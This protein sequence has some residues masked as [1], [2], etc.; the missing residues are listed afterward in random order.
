MRK[1]GG[2]IFGEG[3][4]GKVVDAKDLEKHLGQIKSIVFYSNKNV[5][6]NTQSNSNSSYYIKQQISVSASVWNNRNSSFVEK[7]NVSQIV[8]KIFFNQSA[9]QNVQNTSSK[10]VLETFLK[11]GTFPKGNAVFEEIENMR[12]VSSLDIETPLFKHEGNTILFAVVNGNTICPVYEKYDMDLS[13]FMKIKDNLT[14]ENVKAVI[15]TLLYTVEKLHNN[16][17]YHFD[18]KPGNILYK[19]STNK[20]VLADYGLLNT[21][22]GSSMS[23]GTEMFQSP[24]LNF[25]LDCRMIPGSDASQECQDVK[26]SYHEMKMYYIHTILSLLESARRCDNEEIKSFV[27]ECIDHQDRTRDIAEKISKRQSKYFADTFATNIENALASICNIDNSNSNSNSN[28]NGSLSKKCPT[29]KYLAEELSELI[30]QKNE[31][32]AIGKTIQ[33]FLKKSG[34]KSRHIIDFVDKLV[35]ANVFSGDTEHQDF[36]F[37]EEAIEFFENVMQ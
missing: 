33:I 14:E 13:A 15:R 17:L 11:T 32:H 22:Y 28:G 36:Y 6:R 30:L 27:S 34:I 7:G 35:K 23:E 29:I 8:F 37:I 24:F 21:L 3:T 16:G 25:M 2:N 19:K 9:Q 26:D 10:S 1:R 4:Y 18:I 31:L 20:F 5:P 12:I